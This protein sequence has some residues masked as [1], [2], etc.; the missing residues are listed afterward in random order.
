M[1]KPKLVASLLL[2]AVLLGSTANAD[3]AK[4]K[5]PPKAC[6]G[7][8]F[9]QLDFWVGD[10]NLS[11]NQGKDK[12]MGTAHN[13]I[14]K[15]ALGDCVITEKFSMPGFHGTS[16]SIFHKQSGKWRQTWVDD[17]GGYFDLAGGPAP[18]D[19]DYD[20]GLELVHPE[21]MKAPF[22]RMIWQIKDADHLVWRWQSK[23]SEGQ[24]W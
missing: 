18:K 1:I 11:Y 3:T 20:F 15:S 2:V 19:A 22:L 4:P 12:P 9:R 24:N 7:P 5:P 17:Q 13:L 10:W 6:Q 16:L 14:T 23:K 8:E 21:G